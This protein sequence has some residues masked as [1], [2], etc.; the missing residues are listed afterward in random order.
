VA[1]EAKKPQGDHL[2][3]MVELSREHLN[4]QLRSINFKAQ[5]QD[6]QDD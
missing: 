1:R 2:A 4:C 5:Q 3:L 6:F